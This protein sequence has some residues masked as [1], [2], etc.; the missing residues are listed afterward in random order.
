MMLDVVISIENRGIWTCSGGT[1]PWSNGDMFVEEV[2]L[3]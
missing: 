1:M 2:L 3:A